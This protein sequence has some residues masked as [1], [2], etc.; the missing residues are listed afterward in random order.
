MSYFYCR[1][2]QVSAYFC[3]AI[4][5]CFIVGKSSQLYLLNCEKVGIKMLYKSDTGCG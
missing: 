1:T 4:T 3:P 5:P 2:T